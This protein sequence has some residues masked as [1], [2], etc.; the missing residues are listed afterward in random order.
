MTIPRSLVLALALIAGIL[1]AFVARAIPRKT[2][3]PRLAAE[4]APSASTGRASTP[5]TRRARKTASNAAPVLAPLW[6]L[7]SLR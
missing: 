5:S 4:H 2:S 3:S 7:A 6:V 1:S